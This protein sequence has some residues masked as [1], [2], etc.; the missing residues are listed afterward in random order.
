MFNQTQTRYLIDAVYSSK[1]INSSSAQDLIKKLASKESIYEKKN[2]EQIFKTTSEINRN[3]SAYIFQIIDVIN[4]AMR[5]HKRISFNLISYDENGKKIFR[6]DGYDYHASPY[7][8]INNFGNY[9]L[10]AYYRSK[11]G[12]FNV[13]KLDRMANVCVSDWDEKPMKEAG[14]PHDF[15]ISDYLNEHIYIYGG[16]VIETELLLKSPEEIIN[17]KEWFPGSSKITNVNG[18]I[19]ASVKCNEQALLYW[20]MQ[21]GTGIVVLSPDSLKQKVIDYINEMKKNYEV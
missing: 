10:I 12:P 13:F 17:V 18:E 16:D 11:Y 5:T 21:Y 20:I 3:Q 7:Y 9:Y 6:N 19:H 4:E 8:L 1:N 14:V 15:K 2:Y